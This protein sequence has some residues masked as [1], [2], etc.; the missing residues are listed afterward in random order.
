MNSPSEP[1]I[2]SA[3]RLDGGI[4]VHFS[5]GRSAIFSASLLLSMREQAEDVPEPDPDEG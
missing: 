2:V 4:I 5:D 1:H 3:E